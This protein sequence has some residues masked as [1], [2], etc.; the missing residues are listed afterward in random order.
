MAINRVQALQILGLKA[1]AL[2][3]QITDAYHRLH[4]GAERAEA[5]GHPERL[6]RLDQAYR[7]L[8]AEADPELKYPEREQAKRAQQDP[9][10]YE[11]RKERHRMNQSNSGAVKLLVVILVLAAMA[12]VWYLE[13]IPGLPKFPG[14]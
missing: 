7:L 13:L 5:D 6:R 2:P 14:K 3:E 4:P 1:G 10:E 8:M 12:A 11:R 9:D